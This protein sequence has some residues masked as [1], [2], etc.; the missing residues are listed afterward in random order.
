MP[1]KPR[2]LKTT[3]SVCNAPREKDSRHALCETHRKE[4]ESRNAQ[5]WR[6]RHPEQLR[7][8]RDRENAA[9]KKARTVNPVARKPRIRKREGL[10]KICGRPRHTRKYDRV[11]LCEEHL[12][13]EHRIRKQEMRGKER[14]EGRLRQLPEPSIDREVVI[15]PEAFERVKPVDVRGHKVTRLAAVGEWGR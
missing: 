1:R 2:T 13:E 4:A 3:C 6:E 15:G 5:R 10:C 11:L 14:N 9:R 7:A 8:I 12:R